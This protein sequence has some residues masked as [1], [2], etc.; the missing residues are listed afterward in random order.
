MRVG[1]LYPGRA[2]ESDFPLIA[3][4]LTPPVEVSVVHTVVPSDVVAVEELKAVGRDEYLLS[5]AGEL[6]AYDVDVATWAC[7]SGSF[8]W[9]R[10]G[11][12]RQAELISEVL[13]VP[14]TSTSLSFLDVL[15]SLE[16]KRVSVVSP[17]T[18]GVAAGFVAFLDSAGVEVVRMFNSGSAS[19]EEIGR[20]GGDYVLDLVRYGDDP[21]AE[22]VLLPDT[23]LHT[24]AF[25]E[26]A[27]D[28][29][30]KRVLTSNQVTLWGAL[31]LAAWSAT[32]SGCGSLF[33]AESSR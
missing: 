11:A 8:L 10:G 32:A 23:A 19:A 9:N 4:R 7:T 6:K 1:I 30:G 24:A 18:D 3:S 15:E 33:Q 25:L 26:E 22:A 14:A 2:A 28:I 12:I 31:R 21:A 27:E 13:D 5:G 16:I 29:A 20:L 17:Y